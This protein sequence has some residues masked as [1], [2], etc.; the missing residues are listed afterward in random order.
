MD[1][2]RIAVTDPRANNFI[3]TG[4]LVAATPAQ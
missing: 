2:I 1:M 4:L 3:S